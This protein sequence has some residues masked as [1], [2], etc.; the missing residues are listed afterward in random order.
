MI[1]VRTGEASR[2]KENWLVLHKRDD[3]AVAGWDPEQHPK[4]VISG[5]TNDEIAAHPERLWTRAG[6]VKA[7]GH[8]RRHEAP[9]S[10]EL[11]QLD[12]LGSKGTWTLQGRELALTNLDKVLFPARDKHEDSVTKRDLIRYYASHRAGSP[13]LPR[14]SPAE[15][16]PLPRRRRAEGLLAEA[17]SQVRTRMDRPLAQRCGR[18]G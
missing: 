16:P 6:E 13:P 18:P 3:A 1:L 10:D 4:S 14:R 2:G 7:P 15:S 17:G 9:T 12:S 11:E 5:R 8:A